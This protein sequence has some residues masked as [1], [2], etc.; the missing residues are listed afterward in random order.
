MTDDGV[1]VYFVLFQVFDYALNDCT[2]LNNLVEV[3]SSYLTYFSML[4]LSVSYLCTYMAIILVNAIYINGMDTRVL[5]KSFGQY[6]HS[7]YL[8]CSSCIVF[9]LQ[10]L[11]STGVRAKAMGKTLR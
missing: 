7:K 5:Q 3:V 11:I 10:S 4:N 1:E 2:V 9:K 6:F 8:P